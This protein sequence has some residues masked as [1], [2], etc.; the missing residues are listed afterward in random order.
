MPLL[1]ARPLAN[2]PA[3]TKGVKECLTTS[4][5]GEHTPAVAMVWLPALAVWFDSTL[6][7]GGCQRVNG[8]LKTIAIPANCNCHLPTPIS[9]AFGSGWGKHLGWCKPQIFP[10]TATYLSVH[11]VCKASGPLAVVATRGMCTHCRPHP[12]GGHG[13]R[14]MRL[15][16]CA[17]PLCTAAGAGQA[18][19]RAAVSLIIAM[20]QE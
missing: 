11:R 4:R 8:K 7:P 2:Q 19:P 14:C 18:G 5:G 1:P 9:G 20:R 6:C 17:P 10:T 3:V 15:L 12:A 13:A 16:R